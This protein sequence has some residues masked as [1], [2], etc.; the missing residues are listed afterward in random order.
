[1]SAQPTVF[2]VD[3]D[4]QVRKSLTFLLKSA[5]FESQACAT[6]E[7]F[8][9][10]FDP[11]TPSCMILDIRLSGMNGLEFASWYGFWAPKGVPA[12]VVTWLNKAANEATVEIDKA[13][14]FAKLGMESV[15][16]TPDD[17]AR[18]IANDFKRSE[19]LLKAADFKPM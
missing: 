7:E 9:A 16:G 12:E 6:A 18:Y 1:M 10:T 5:G 17:F 11:L 8:L 4:Q 13:G 19:A 15:T 2:V 14:R 3:D